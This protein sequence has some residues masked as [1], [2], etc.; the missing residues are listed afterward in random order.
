[1]LKAGHNKLEMTHVLKMLRNGRDDDSFVCG[2]FLVMNF[3]P[4]SLT[5]YVNTL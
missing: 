1:M 3:K 5:K 2:V 4:D